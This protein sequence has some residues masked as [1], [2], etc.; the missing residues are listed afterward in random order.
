[1]TR[2]APAAALALVAAALGAGPARAREAFVGTVPNGASYS[3][4]TCH[5]NGD[6]GE[7][8]ND[9]GQDLLEAGGA[10]PDANPDDQNAGYVGSP[11][12]SDVCDLD[13]D[14]DGYVNGEELGDPTCTWVQGDDDSEAAVTNP[15]DGADFPGDGAALCSS[16]H[17]GRG[18]PGALAL[19]GL[20][21][22]RL[23]AAHRISS[24]WS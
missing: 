1:M 19:C 22:A 14:G 2:A 3:C 5:S 8:W 24:R 10:N 13:S 23:L 15:G 9:F 4:S 21:C 7:G 17:R 20:L 16:H 18:T 12:W 11:R 6:G